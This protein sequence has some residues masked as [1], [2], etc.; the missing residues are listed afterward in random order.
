MNKL[1]HILSFVLVVLSL[2]V[3]G[4]IEPVNVR[5]DGSNGL[6]S[7]AIL[8]VSDNKLWQIELGNWEEEFIIQSVKNKVVFGID[9]SN[10]DFNQSTN[11]SY[12]IT[13]DITYK[14]LENGLLVDH[15]YN[16]MSLEINYNPSRG[17]VY[18]DRSV[19]NFTGGLDVKIKITEIEDLITGSIVNTVPDYLFLEAEIETER[20]YK[21]DQTSLPP[22]SMGLTLINGNLK[23]TW[24]YVLGA[25][26][27]ELEWAWV[28]SYTGELVGELPELYSASQVEFNFSENAT[29]VKTRGFN[30]Y[31]IP[32]IYG[33]GY[34]VVRYRAIG[35]GGDNFK[36]PMEGVWNYSSS[37][38]AVSSAP[39]YIQV[40]AH[41]GNGINYGAGMSFIENG[42]KS[43]GVT[44]MDG[45]LK[46]RQSQA[47][48]NS[49]EKIIV[50]STIYD[51]Y[52][53]PAIGVMST[54]VNQSTLGY[55]DNLNMHS[56]GTV[57]NK[58]HFDFDNSATNCGEYTAAP[59][60]S[61][62]TSAGAAN[63]YSE[64]NSDTEGYNAYLPNAEG[65]PFVQVKYEND[66]TGRVKRVGGIG[67]D[68]QIGRTDAGSN[69][70]NE[71][72]YTEYI[73]ATPDDY[74]LYKLF[75][76]EGNSSVNYTKIVTKDVHGQLSV[77]ITDPMS[78]TVAT[79]MM[80][81]SPEGLENI[82]GNEFPAL[83]PES[84]DLM[85]YNTT[86]EIDGI[87]E[88][89]TPLLVT[90]SG[91]PHVFNYDFTGVS[92]QSCLPPEICFDCAYTLEISII[93]DDL[94]D[95]SNAPS[96]H[97]TYYGT[98][99]VA[100]DENGEV[101]LSYEVGTIDE[102][103]F[104]IDCDSYVFSNLHSG[105][106]TFTLAFPK[107][108]NYQVVKRLVVSEAPIDYY[109]NE[110]IENTTC[111]LTYESFLETALANINPEACT[112]YQ[113]CE[114]NFLL[115]HG[116]FE[117]YAINNPGALEDDYDVLRQSYI[118][119]CGVQTPCD[120]M[121]PSMIS[122]LRKGGQY[123]LLISDNDV[124]S[125][126]NGLLGGS[127]ISDYLPDTDNNGDPIM[128]DVDGDGTFDK[129]PSD[130]TLTLSEFEIGYQ[131]EW[132]QY[133][134]ELHPE[135]CYY[136]FC[137]THEDIF[138][139]ENSFN[140]T[141]HYSDACDQGFFS[142]FSDYNISGCD[143]AGSSS[144]DP[145]FDYFAVGTVA[146]T[147]MLAL[148][149]DPY[150]DGSGNLLSIFQMAALMAG[151]DINNFGNS[152]C[153]IDIH[154]KNFRNLYA[155]RRFQ[156]IELLKEENCSNTTTDCIQDSDCITAPYG[157][158]I[159]RYVDFESSLGF[160]L[161]SN[162][163]W[164][165]LANSGSST[166][167]ASC[168]SQ[169]S[170]MADIWMD[171]LAGCVSYLPTGE[172]WVSGQV[173]YDLV[174]ESLIDVCAGGCSAEW[175]FLAQE[176]P[177]YDVAAIPAEYSS[178]QE[179]IVNLLGVET[180][181][182][183][184]LLVFNPSPGSGSSENSIV[185]F[186]DDCSCNTLMATEDVQEF[187]L[188]HGFVPSN[189]FSEKCN[190]ESYDT[191]G[192]LVIEGAEIV[193]LDNAEIFTTNTYP[194]QSE[195]INC[196]EIQTYIDDFL[197][198]YSVNY[199]DE[200]LLFLA[201]VNETTNGVYLY[202]QLLEFIGECALVDGGADVISAH[203]LALVDLL[204]KL[205][206][207]GIT[208]PSPVGIP[209]TPQTLPEY[210]N[211]VLYNCGDPVNETYDYQPF[212]GGFQNQ[213]LNI[214]ILDPDCKECSV[215]LGVQ[216]ELNG[217]LTAENYFENIVSFDDI[218]SFSGANGGLG[219]Y[220]YVNVTVN[221]LSGPGTFS[222]QVQMSHK[223]CFNVSTAADAGEI[224]SGDP[225][226]EEELSCIDI[227]VMNAEFSAQSLYDD[228]LDE[229]FGI[230]RQ[231]YISRCT[232]LTDETFK[233]DYDNNKYQYTLLYYDQS[234][235]LVKT[236]PPK[237]VAEGMLT[238]TQAEEAKAHF[239]TNGVSGPAI[240]PDYH[241]V[242]RYKHNS[243]NQVVSVTTPDGGTSQ[244]WYD[245]IGR[246]VVSQNAKQAEFK[247][248]NIS[249]DYGNGLEM[250]AYSYTRY[251]KL[252]RVVEVG[253]LIQPT[254]MTNEI[255]KDPIVLENWL[256]T[257]V[258]LGQQV[259][260][261]NVTQIYYD[262]GHSAS[263]EVEFGAEE[264]GNTRNRITA[265]S[266]IE[267]YF[268]ATVGEWVY[269][270]PEYTCH[271]KYDVHGNVESYLQEVK[272]LGEYNNL[273]RKVDYEYD[274]ISGNPNYIY[275]QKGKP[276]Q[277]I[278][279]YIYD[280][281]NRLKE[282][283]TSSD[284]QIW[285]RD[286]NYE[287]REDG[288][289]ART[290]IGEM[291]V[292]GMDYAYTLHGWLKSLN[293]GVLN[294]DFDMGKDGAVN[295]AIEYSNLE[296]DA[297][298]LVAQDALAYTVGYYDGDYSAISSNTVGYGNMQIGS[299]G[300]AFDTDKTDLYNGNITSLITNLTATNGDRLNVSANTYHYDQLHR[301]KEMHVF[302]D[303][304]I[305]ASNNLSTAS[306]S[307]IDFSTGLGDY[308][309][310]VG[311]DM[312]GNI[313][314]L[315]RMSFTDITVGASHD[316]KMDNFS[317]DY[318]IVDPVTLQSSNKLDHVIDG[319]TSTDL[320][321][322]GDIK[323]N[324][325]A[326]NYTYH[327]DGSLKSDLD[328]GIAYID[329]YPSGK[330]KFIKRTN[331]S[332]ASDMYFEYG[333]MG[334]RSL[335][336]EIYKSAPGVP[337]P[338]EEWKYTYYASD[339]NGITL[340]IYDL[341]KKVV[342]NLG[343]SKI[344]SMLYGGS[345]LGMETTKVLVSEDYNPITACHTDGLQSA[346][347]EIG[348][349]TI[350]A[351]P[352]NGINY[353]NLR[354]KIDGEELAFINT[355]NYGTVQEYAEALIARIHEIHPGLTP[356]L[357]DLGTT[358]NSFNIVIS[359][360]ISGALN[361][362][363]E[364]ESL[365]Y[366]L[367]P[368]NTNM[369]STS[370]YNTTNY[371]QS[372]LRQPTIGECYSARVLGKK[373]YELSNHLGNVMEVITD[374]KI[375]ELSGQQLD[376]ENLSIGGL[377]VNPGNS[378]FDEVAGTNY[379]TTDVN[380]DGQVDLTVSH[381]NYH[382][383][384]Q[385]NAL[386][387]PGET[388]TVK[389]DMLSH[390]INTKTFAIYRC[391]NGQHILNESSSALGM[392]SHN[393]TI[394]LNP[395]NPTDLTPILVRLKWVGVNYGGDYGE[396][397]LSNIQVHGEGDVFGVNNG[398]DLSYYTADVV[399]YS[400]YYPF[401]MQMPGRNGTV[402]GGEYRY[403][404]NGMETDKEVSGTGN[405]YTTQ[406]RQ[407][408][409]RLG[410]WKSLDPLAGKFP[411]MSPF[412][413]MDNNPIV[414]ID[415]R[416]D[417]IV[418]PDKHNDHQKN[419]KIDLKLIKNFRGRN[420]KKLIAILDKSNYLVI[421]DELDGQKRAEMNAT[422]FVRD[423]D[424]NIT[425]VKFRPVTTEDYLVPG[426]GSNTQNQKEID[427]YRLSIEI[428]LLESE[429]DMND[430]FDSET[431]Q[432]ERRELLDKLQKRLFNLDKDGIDS[433]LG[434]GSYLEINNSKGY[435]DALKAQM[436]DFLGEFEFSRE[437][438]LAHELVHAWQNIVGIDLSKDEREIMATALTN[439][440]GRTRRTRRAGYNAKIPEISRKQERKYVRLF[441]RKN[442]EYKK[443]NRKRE[444]KKRKRRK[445][446]PSI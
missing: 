1:R 365:E 314:N 184:H 53:R 320:F 8:E 398:I 205:N 426:S 72:H 124:T 227:L 323:H 266:V 38:G 71:A 288:Y 234:G 297:H 29:R 108:G 45:V 413:G 311:Y 400:D 41:E 263:A 188:A 99:G 21:F 96:G 164:N 269:P 402:S 416:G 151:D 265:T 376:L 33:D 411:N 94:C 259:V 167:D 362:V 180:A 112:T 431:N 114:Y 422:T 260:R 50:G 93:P 10:L 349:Q 437:L 274:L 193:A 177:N 175:P 390:N 254:V 409:P 67:P 366:Y 405:S 436:Q 391:D 157:N 304:N 305:T 140:S 414:N 442:R 150:D 47:K 37:T 257:T 209:Y 421:I 102:N 393:I 60:M 145:L 123:A 370:A 412:V 149:S 312:N 287:Y 369:Y 317:Y 292:Q 187:I 419:I 73:Y 249:G 86:D 428:D 319:I 237:G 158:K 408:D 131:N 161:D 418:I 238:Q 117:V 79:Y 342:A 109:W 160:D 191:D 403:A 207:N 271:Y 389:Y 170:S 142:A 308:E 246:L 182:C 351:P 232:E 327:A 194:C 143:A 7:N 46:P 148:I 127:P 231:N 95:L 32:L 54:P 352:F 267:G 92:F 248:G 296:N 11:Y 225:F 355:N 9:E 118:D 384:Y 307:N 363:I 377:C 28:N 253:E 105:A 289:L 208:T 262:Q 12:K 31:E 321:G 441:R 146:Y 341:D 87:I 335:K 201:Y 435:L 383:S 360:N 333:P 198:T 217:Y 277:Y 55:V 359:E 401:G 24:P 133:F 75:G 206:E 68:H 438:I 168:H 322:Y 70:P 173:T 169:C 439:R 353:A 35:R 356:V 424:L 69:A 90:E 282:V 309:V 66:P 91:A 310:N 179:V 39:N 116:T 329:W 107:I 204:N 270:E 64:Y 111:L 358:S 200:P 276:D 156:I 26:E 203:S 278:H 219:G 291:K 137:S 337:L 348:S 135:Y 115:E 20:Y 371:S 298:G 375:L 106:E 4:A 328:E 285:D 62:V 364:V 122:D 378:I 48:L 346:V 396:F 172:T 420:F 15:F 433:G 407:Y 397:V 385:Q 256:T 273:Y 281:D 185:Q 303:D 27:Y 5:L 154:W 80:G 113:P 165:E 98:N 381:P 192:N 176:N 153:N 82:E 316:N 268:E 199:F 57:Y 147:S 427:Y 129:L 18:Q 214:Y 89:S 65:Y 120:I 190:C 77:A 235:S 100:D 324:Q 245:A 34:I 244:Y 49:Q 444:R 19:F 338:T 241:Y 340:A 224:C 119:E 318:S 284:G 301:F 121:Y 229:Q 61:S 425:D 83:T 14:V 216:S 332:L 361:G 240:F 202:D 382:F 36:I 181:E 25:E 331:T 387:I 210:Y 44:Y 174:R 78:R 88:V 367:V 255:A 446:M 251:D 368:T 138:E 130:P 104:N 213:T 74:E 374:R 315:T 280:K 189:Y 110:Y 250:G 125:I 293:S 379:T 3:F 294:A 415:P 22:Q 290:E 429:I 223:T 139:F 195:C 63:Y 218:F 313:T 295:P 40:T 286:V 17:S 283:F 406:F 395:A 155:S 344:E 410:R 372:I 2:N 220:I 222:G 186:L 299:V 445:S 279:H 264:Y 430:G 42:V 272:E 197:Q 345:R 196:E 239:V 354:L 134:I 302:S 103:S 159:A 43:V 212:F 126:F 230:F 228:Y 52:G 58:T 97:I 81:A 300:S 166:L 339:A 386:F 85:L 330:I 221:N 380:S 16:G 144:T 275:Y 23:I 336:V 347:I 306:R 59:E 233:V 357:Y 128:I 132:A 258:A 101:H 76:N 243:L 6:V 163:D 443:A 242:T 399:S 434:S 417:E 325:T 13:G 141:V 171:N 247:L 183:S 373:M 350:I 30:T 440:F 84:K 261:N 215:G 423:E 162:P 252:G 152:I 392:F 178:F 394:P 56:D 432:D 334:I 211:S 226:G 343:L 326:G 136:N 404:F 388:Y 51:Y 236:V